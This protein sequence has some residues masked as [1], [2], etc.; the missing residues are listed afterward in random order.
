MIYVIIGQSGAGKTTFVR[1]RFIRATDPVVV[2]DIIPYT[3]CNGFCLI[4]KYG[5]GERTEG[6]DTL[7]YNAKDKIKRQIKKL[8]EKKETAIVLEGD[9]INNNDMFSFLAT[10]RMPVKLYLIT[11]TL[12]TSMKRLQAAGSKITPQFV[13]ATKTK[14]LNNFIKWGEVFAGE[15]F[16]NDC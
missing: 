3:K 15:V 12:E 13:R 9:R 11:C 7:A 4:G 5:T 8:I 2:E 1:D 6:T 16:N 10:L 14:S